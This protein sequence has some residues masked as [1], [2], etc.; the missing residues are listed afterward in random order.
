MVKDSTDTKPVARGVV[1][2]L[3]VGLVWLGAAVYA[4]H[5]TITGSAENVSGVLRAAAA[6]LPGVVATTLVAGASIGAA[7]GRR[8]RS[9]GGRL[10]AGLALGALFGLAL[11]A[12]TRFVYG[13]GVAIMVL[14]IAASIIGGAL[15]VLP[16]DV[17]KAGLWGTTWVFVT[18]VIFGVAQPHLLRLLGTGEAAN[19]R[20]VVGQSLV[21]GLVA[22]LCTLRFLPVGGKRVLW[23]PVAGALPGLVLLGAQQ[24][25][26]AGGSAVA[27]L[28]HGFPT[29]SPP[30]VELSDSARLR[31]ALIVLAAGGLIAML[32]GA[33]KSLLS[34]PSRRHPLRHRPSPTWGSIDAFHQGLA[35][36][37]LDAGESYGFALAGGYALQAAGFLK[38][39]T[40]DID[41]FTVWEQR[42]NFETAASAIIDAYLAAGLRVQAER[43]HDGFI[44]LTVSDGL[45][46]AKVDL[47]VDLRVNDP[48][49][50]SLGP[51]LHPDDVV[52]NK[53][54]AL[55]ERAHACDFIDI[56]AALQSGRYDPSMLLQL[57]T[58]S[59][60]T[61]DGRVFADALARA[62]LLADDDFARYGLVGEQLDGLR[63]RFALWRADLLD[64]AGPTR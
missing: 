52:A 59:D 15:A 11:A 62:Q 9:A 51:V 61:F 37:G 29:E 24:L 56:D 12:G 38:R 31:H 55:Y 23:Y 8:L 30:L 6:A 53:M 28:V 2:Q 25:T 20:F 18:G 17:L 26:R 27:Q 19:D 43:R 42:S 4:A 10:R 36:I 5:A 64:T 16:G 41:L 34:R 1:A 7:A 22:A 39:A 49:R 21:A 32:A 50:I 60:I 48:V 3:F 35:R 47:G 54:R 14:A 58:R 57:A 63:H 44:R 13:G 46:T 33:L 45:Q 40:E